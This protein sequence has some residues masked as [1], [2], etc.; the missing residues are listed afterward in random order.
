[1]EFDEDLGVNRMALQV[2][3][4]SRSYGL[5]EIA[6][7]SESLS[8]VEQQLRGTQALIVR[9]N[10]GFVSVDALGL[11]VHNWLVRYPQTRKRALEGDFQ[12]RSVAKLP[13]VNSE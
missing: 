6:E 10:E 9:A 7:S 11:P 12:G 8:R 5:P 2:C 4:Y 13:P 1:M 3:R